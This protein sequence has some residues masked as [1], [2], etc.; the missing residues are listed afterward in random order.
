LCGAKYPAL[1]FQQSPDAFVA[2][3]AQAGNDMARNWLRMAAS[4]PGQPP[5]AIDATKASGDC[6]KFKAGYFAPHKLAGQ[7][8]RGGANG[9]C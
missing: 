6:W 7:T 2:S 1:N 9:R 5:P 3:I 4:A 8:P